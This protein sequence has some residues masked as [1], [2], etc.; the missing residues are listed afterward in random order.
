VALIAGV[1]AANA[2]ASGQPPA[3]APAQEEQQKQ[4]AR[5]PA[6]GAV[7]QRE[8]QPAAGQVKQPDQQPR[9]GTTQ[10]PQP[11]AS[12]QPALRD[13]VRDR[14]DRREEKATDQRPQVQPR[15]DRREQ[16]GDRRERREG[17]DRGRGRGWDSFDDNQRTRIRAGFSRHR[18]NRADVDFQIS[19]GRAVPRHVRT[20][21]VPREVWSV[22][23]EYRRYVYIWV[24][25]EIL[26]I[27]PRTH[28]IVAILP[29]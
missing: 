6:P 19:I 17:A 22:W 18:A 26:V 9:Q 2:Q 29:A 4:K 5:Q 20:Y 13:Q 21:P 15:V 28:R 10:T 7:K 27:N 8:Q 1:A 14:K 3:S 11:G 23:P 24:G 16:T 12:G 25:D